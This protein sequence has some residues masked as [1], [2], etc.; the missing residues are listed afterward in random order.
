MINL[1]TG[2]FYEADG[3][4]FLVGGNVPCIGNKWAVKINKRTGKF[5]KIDSPYS[6]GM[7]VLYKL[8][9][10]NFKLSD[11]TFEFTNDFRESLIVLFSKDYYHQSKFDRRDAEELADKFIIKE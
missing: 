8:Q 5:R 6:R 9:N 7:E 3:R 4:I 2:K 1:E 10:D 11:K